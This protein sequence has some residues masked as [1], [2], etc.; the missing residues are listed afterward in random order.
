M[1]AQ[2]AD[3]MQL[4]KVGDSVFVKATKKQVKRKQA[5]SS[6]TIVATIEEKQVSGLF[7]RLRWETAGLGGEPAG[8]V[9]KRVYHWSDLK[10][11]T[12]KG[13]AL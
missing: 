13:E 11:R 8:A 2:N 9:S 3:K 10:M 4:F 12:E 7:Y 1:L 6:W 5:V